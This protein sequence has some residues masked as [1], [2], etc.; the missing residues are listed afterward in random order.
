[1]FQQPRFAPLF[2]QSKS[3]G[4][5]NARALQVGIGS[6]QIHRIADR[7]RGSEPTQ[8]HATRKDLREG[9]EAD[10]AT[11]LLVH[12]WF[13]SKVGSGLFGFSIVEEIIGIIFEEEEVVLLYYFE[14]VRVVR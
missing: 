5:C 12:F 9:I 7:F 3:H 10:H 2:Q 13:E 6:D 1:M 8:S 4:L 11:C 14:T